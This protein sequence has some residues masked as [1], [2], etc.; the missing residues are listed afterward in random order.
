MNEATLR[1]VCILD[2]A[3][4]LS[5]DHLISRFEPLNS[6]RSSQTTDVS[7]IGSV[8]NGQLSSYLTYLLDFDYTILTL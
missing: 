6:V 4:H 7:G 3:M 8:P 2:Q 1:L 5:T